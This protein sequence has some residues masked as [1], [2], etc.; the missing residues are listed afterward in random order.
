MLK[1]MIYSA[2]N[3]RHAVL[4]LSIVIMLVG[5]FA[6]KQAPLDVFPEFA[7]IKVEIQ[8]EAPGLSTE[9][10]EQLISMPLE[11][12]LNGTPHLKT[13]RSKS[14]VGLSSVVML[15][16]EGT[17]IQE[18][19][20][21]VQERLSLA[22]TRLPVVAKAPVLMPPLS[23]LSRVLK[24]G[25]SSKQ[26]SQMDISNITMWTIRPRLMSVP[27]IANVAVWGQRDKQLQI[28]IDP[29]RLR[30]AGLTIPQII[31]AAGDAASI[32]SGGFVDTPNQR[33]ALRHKNLSTQP[34]E[35]AKI[36]VDF[37]NGSPVRLGDVAEITIGSPPPIGDAVINHGDGL[38]LIVEKHPNA[39]TIE[40][41]KNVELA[42]AELKLALHQLEI[43]STIFRPATFIERAIQNLQNALLIGAVLVMGILM[44]FLRNKRAAFISICAIPLSLITAVLVLTI[45]NIGINTMV[46]AGLVIALGE[47]VDDAIIDVE[48]IIRRLKL[49]Q[50]SEKPKSK[51]NVIVNASLEVRSAVVY[52]TMIVMVVFLPVLFLDGI[53]GAFF[54]PLATAYLL[55]ILASLVVALTVT[56]ALSYFL[57]K[58]ESDDKEIS[59]VTWLR[60]RYAKL[61]DVFLINPK[62]IVVTTLLAFSIAGTG[63]LFLGSEF[64]PKFKETDF[65]MHFLERPGSSI[66]QM[67]KM[68]IRASNDLLAIP[69]VRN[70]GAHIGRAEAADE[71]VGPNF[72]ELWISIDPELNYDK[73]VASIQQAMQGYSGIFADVQTYLK[74]RS[75]EV[76]SGTSSSIVVRLFGPDLAVLR[77]QA[78]AIKSTMQSVDGVTDLKVEPQVLVP[79]IEI[80][81]K[82]DAAQRYGINTND[83]RKV[84]SM[85]LKG[86]KVGEVYETQQKVDVVII[87][88]ADSK[89][90]LSA[91][92]Q[93]PIDSPF[94]SQLRIKDVA[95]V[96]F[97]GMPNE[98]KREAVSRRID[99]VANAK[100]RDLGAVASDIENKVLKMQFPSG[101]YPQ[102]LGEYT[103][104]K[105]AKNRLAGLSI[106]MLF[107][108]V[109]IVY[110]DFKS[111]RHTLILVASLPFALIGG[112]IGVFISGGV[113]SLGSMVGFIAV[114]GIAAR[115]GILLISHY[116]HLIISE[117][118]AMSSIELIKRGS[119]ERLIP[120]LMTALATSLALLPIIFKGP[121]SGYEIE[122]P[123]AIVVVSGLL[124]S[125]I[126][127]LVLLPSIFL[128]FCMKN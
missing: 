111:Y 65:L 83:I 28:V 30:A 61:L 41:T 103:A 54:K 49:N 60:N 45:F 2:V 13:I 117:N 25:V 81:L 82:Q 33:I 24:I 89:L 85:V 21:F 56:P 95:D 87:G 17:N 72:T 44:I 93:L 77:Q 53:A 94:G 120:I 104:Q 121:I 7:P 119:N 97:V 75:K 23:S 34:D 12:L 125:T 14:V 5:L 59:Q 73:T 74:E 107:A 98:I 52:A 48:N 69:G 100:N 123:L 40:V 32:E 113:V 51:L 128:K 118:V 22:A 108:I 11:Q 78:E 124:T 92:Q 80:R 39:N 90:D 50:L 46:I 110:V 126:L 109:L 64:L 67:K 43:D 127:N 38:L 79:Q 70:F 1:N 86:T 9:E 27:G 105:A 96:Y 19:R 66:E 29:N 36:V 106:L 112:V 8:T 35:L 3:G 6:A 37:K 42:L 20:Q 55:A 76:L 63:S 115:N 102:F 58:S 47:V 71:V 62:K 16:E 114:L 122:Y 31:K 15:F 57:L 91:I 88:N 10:T 68:S 84:T 26:L 4:F 18:A 116:R 99:I 101:Y